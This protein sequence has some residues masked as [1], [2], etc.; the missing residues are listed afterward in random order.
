VLLGLQSNIPLERP[1]LLSG[2]PPAILSLRAD[3]ADVEQRAVSAMHGHNPVVTDSYRQNLAIVDNFISLCEKTVREEPRNELAR[4]YL[5]A[6]YQQKA[7]L[8]ATMVEH[9]VMSD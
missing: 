7:D 8:L 6:A 2:A 3:L 1:V 9:G 5:Y 4:E